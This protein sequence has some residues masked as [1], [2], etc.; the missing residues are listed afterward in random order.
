M[1]RNLQIEA[2][3]IIDEYLCLIG[4]ECKYYSFKEIQYFSTYHQLINIPGK[5]CTIQTNWLSLT[6]FQRNSKFS[7]ILAFT[8]QNSI[9][10]DVIIPRGRGYSHVK[11]YRDV[12]HK[13]VS[14]SPKKQNKTKQQQQQQQ[15]QQQKP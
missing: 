13:W 12:L 1:I 6:S 10:C 4:Y 8:L 15:Q 5:Y 2:Y 7:Y 11:V 3:F 14:F 9:H